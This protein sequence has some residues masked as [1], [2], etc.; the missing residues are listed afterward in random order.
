MCPG[1]DTI[2]L[3]FLQLDHVDAKAEKQRSSTGRKLGGPTLWYWL[4]KNGYP[5]GYQV[6]C[7]NCNSAKRTDCACPL[8]G[9]IHYVHQRML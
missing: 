7:A 9:T 6:L 8:A 4:R 5:A 2:F 3:G 1:C